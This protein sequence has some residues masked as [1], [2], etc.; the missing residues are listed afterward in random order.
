METKEL[1]IM[2]I[3]INKTPMRQVL[4]AP[5]FFIIAK[6]TGLV[7]NASPKAKEPTKPKTVLL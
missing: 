3:T 5:I 1:E 2:P 6:L 7:Q 4:R